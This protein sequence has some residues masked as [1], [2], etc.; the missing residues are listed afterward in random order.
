MLA[1]AWSPPVPYYG[2]ASSAEAEEEEGD[3]RSPPMS[4]MRM[5]A[6][7]GPVRILVKMSSFSSRVALR[8]APETSYVDMYV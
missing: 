7:T 8:Y 5:R 1:N 6:W 4:W 2:V 3:T